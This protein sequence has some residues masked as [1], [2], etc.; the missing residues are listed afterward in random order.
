MVAD[1]M[2]LEKKTLC[3]F[4]AGDRLITLPT[5]APSLSPS[6]PSLTPS[7]RLAPSFSPPAFLYLSS[8]LFSTCLP[9]LTPLPPS[10]S[11]SLTPSLPTPPPSLSLSPPLLTLSTPSLL[12]RKQTKAL[13][14]QGQGRDARLCAGRERFPRQSCR[15]SYQ[16]VSLGSFKSRGVRSVLASECLELPD[17]K[18]T[19]YAVAAR[20]HARPAVEVGISGS[21]TTSLSL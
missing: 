10:I 12:P 15:F 14:I 7:P 2:T 16:L 19:G 21:Y 13:Q 1:M 3:R 17:R 11:P 20:A 9:S 6:P 8:L 4:S 5:S 18:E